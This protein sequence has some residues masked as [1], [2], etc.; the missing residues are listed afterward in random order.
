MLS[1]YINRSINF[2]RQMMNGKHQ[3]T[4]SY[5]SDFLVIGTGIAGLCHSNTVARVV[6]AERRVRRIAEEIEAFFKKTVVAQELI[7]LR[8]IAT[9][10][11]LIIDCAL[12]SKE[13]RGLHYVTD[14]SEQ[15]MVRGTQNT[16]LTQSNHRSHT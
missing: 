14:Y 16:V 11:A 3:I 6:R 4:M 1:A 15:D 10:V 8:N 2:S 12:Q 7:E 9:V 5:T 13:S